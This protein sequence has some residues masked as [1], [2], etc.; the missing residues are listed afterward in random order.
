MSDWDE[1]P[2]TAAMHLH[3]A[4]S[5]YVS[6]PHNVHL[7]LGPGGVKITVICEGAGESSTVIPWTEIQKP[8]TNPV[9]PAAEALIDSFPSLRENLWEKFINPTLEGDA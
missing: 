2:W 5:Q 7:C 1:I 6:C 8:S 9:I 3:E 4:I